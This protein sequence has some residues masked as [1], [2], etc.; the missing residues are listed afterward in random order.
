VS[1]AGTVGQAGAACRLHESTKG[2]GASGPASEGL[3]SGLASR[4]AIASVGLLPV[5]VGEVVP[6]LLG[7]VVPVGELASLS[8]IADVS[9]PEQATPTTVPDPTTKANAK[10]RMFHGA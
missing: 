7:D 3:A 8:G 9:P 10:R 4:G 2:P 1:V 6:E 5:P